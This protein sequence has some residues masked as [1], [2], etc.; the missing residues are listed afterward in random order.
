MREKSR[1]EEL[2]G[3]G[4]EKGRVEGEGKGRGKRESRGEGREGG[5]GEERDRGW[6]MTLHIVCNVYSSS[7]WGAPVSSNA[8]IVVSR[9]IQYDRP[10]PSHCTPVY[11]I[12]R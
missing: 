11:S 12:R 4:V 10:P 3:E 8:G 2:G 5:G 1:V 6:Y 9:A 7:A